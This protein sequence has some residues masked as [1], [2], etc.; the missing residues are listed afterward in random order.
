MKI[1]FY[2]ILKN[3]FKITDLSK[4]LHPNLC[5]SIN[6]FFR[7]FNFD[8]EIDSTCSTLNRKKYWFVHIILFILVSNI[9]R[10]LVYTF[11]SSNDQLFRLFCGDLI[12]FALN[13]V[14]FVA[15]SFV[16]FTSYSLAIFCLL[17]Y[18]PINQLQWLN[19]F[20]AIEGKQCFA[21]QK[22]FLSN[23]AKKFIRFSLTLLL[24]NLVLSFFSRIVCDFSCCFFAFLKLSFKHWLLYA[25]PWIIFTDLWTK[26]CGGYTLASLFIIIICYYYQLRL[27]QMDVYVNWLLK[28]KNFRMSNVRIMNVLN[29]HV[30]IIIEINQFNKFA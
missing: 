23:S 5:V 9:I 2:K 30:K 15:I 3:K 4:P 6:K 29:E 24:F 19:I 8:Y 26:Y 11:F 7:D 14:S 22:I 28:Q 20:N 12:Q 21:K 10:N 16:G 25:L 18:S 1:S 27:K 13:Q 17:H